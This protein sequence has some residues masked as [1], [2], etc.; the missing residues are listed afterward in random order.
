MARQSI[1][2]DSATSHRPSRDD[3]NSNVQCNGTNHHHNQQQH[4]YCHQ[5]VGIEISSSRADEARSNIHQARIDG[6]IP[7]H[8]TIDIQ[9]SNALEVDYSRATVV[10]LYLV[11]RGLRLIQPILRDGKK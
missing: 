5:F 4:H 10:F 6:L 3:T 1:Q 2:L 9:C 11:P 8:V 7:S